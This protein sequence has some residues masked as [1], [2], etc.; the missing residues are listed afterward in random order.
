MFD[1]YD[2]VNYNDDK[3]GRPP[4][5]ALRDARAAVGVL[6]AERM[7]R[8]AASAA[9]RADDFVRQFDRRAY[10]NIKGA[11]RLSELIVTDYKYFQV[12]I[13]RVL[14]FIAPTATRKTKW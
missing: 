2:L 13:V 6:A 7:R 4:Q 5:D 3:R 11:P 8:A 12:V 1:L 14:S 10:H 9:N